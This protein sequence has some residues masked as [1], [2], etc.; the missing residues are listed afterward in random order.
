MSELNT[1]VPG[2]GRCQNT[3]VRTLN[4][5]REV[6]FMKGR[7]TLALLAVVSLV[8]AISGCGSGSATPPPSQDEVIK[9]GAVGPLSPPGSVAAGAELKNA[10]EI[11]IDEINEQGG[12][13]GKKLQL[14]FEDSQG[15]PEKGVSVMEKLITKDQVIIVTGEAH[16]SAAKAEMEVAHRYGIPFVISEAWSDELTLRGYREVFRIAPNNKAFSEKVREFV[17]ANGF[18]R[19]AAIVE[20]TD[21]G[22]GSMDLIESELRALGL[23]HKVMIVDRTSLDFVPQL[24]QLQEFGPDLFV[25]FVTGAGSFLLVKQAYEIGLSPTSKTAM[26][27][28]GMDATFPEFWPNV[29]EAGRYVVFQSPYHAKAKFTDLTEPFVRKY[30]ARFNRT[31]TYVALAG[32]DSIL[33]IA[34]AIKA[35]ESTDPQKIIEALEVISVTGVRGIMEFPTDKGLGVWYHNA[36][37]PMLFLQY[38]EV[39]QAVEDAVIVYP[40]DVATANMQ[41]PE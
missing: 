34:E 28:A 6:K 12:I 39:N 30:E 21:F 11:A 18:Q 4:N 19:V 20:D 33:V 17:E 13:L 8:L 25:H 10:M 32:Y 3:G 29:G 26:F 2:N 40:A 36:D 24:I 1:H 35:A 14:V 22:I 9:I 38:T 37:S 23:E 31:P 27:M 7:R 41:S 16:S 5:E 15:T